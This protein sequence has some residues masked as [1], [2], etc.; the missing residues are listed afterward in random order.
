MPHHEGGV[1]VVFTRREDEAQS[2]VERG[3]H[4]GLGSGRV[5]HEEVG[6]GDRGTSLGTIEEV[7]AGRVVLHCGHED[8]PN[9]RRRRGCGRGEGVEEGL[10]LRYRALGQ[11]GDLV[12][13][14]DPDPRPFVLSEAPLKAS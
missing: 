9:S 8:V 13:A 14:I 12:H 5:G 7:R 3:L 10:L 1:E 11:F 4:L 6:E 2:L